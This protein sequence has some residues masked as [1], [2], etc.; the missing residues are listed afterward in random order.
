MSQ[1]RRLFTQ[2]GQKFGRG[3]VIEPDIRLSVRNRRAAR[4][5]CACGT[6]YEAALTHLLSGRT[7]LCGCLQRERAAESV[8]QL[9]EHGMRDHP[10]YDTWCS[11]MRR[12]YSEQST[13]FSDY[14][15]RGIRVCPGMAQRGR[16]SSPDRGEPRPEA[17]RHD[18]RPG[19]QRGRELRARRR[20]L[21]HVERAKQ[22]PAPQ[23]LVEEARRGDP[24]TWND[25]THPEY[26]EERHDHDLD[27]AEKHHRHYDLEREDERLQA[28]IGGMGDALGEL[29]GELQAAL[30]RIRQLEDG[31]AS[32]L[33]ELRVLDRLRPTCVLCH[34]QVAD[35]QTTRG[36]ARHRLRR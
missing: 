35:R 17:G 12:C 1:R 36:P 28:L 15:G 22:Q 33:G 4:L 24:V 19:R 7:K 25:H 26:A 21:G 16:A 30:G 11:M 29:R 8:R 34:D 3:V 9:H 6:V 18:A 31:R 2:V 14:G 13:N 32:V 5:L 10:L 27:Y 20:P 23:A